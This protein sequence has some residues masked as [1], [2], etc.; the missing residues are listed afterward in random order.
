MTTS[1][2][3]NRNKQETEQLLHEALSQLGYL[4]QELA[5]AGVTHNAQ[6]EKIEQLEKTLGQ[7]ASS[8]LG[9]QAAAAETQGTQGESVE[10]ADRLQYYATAN[11]ALQAQLD[12]AITQCNMYYHGTIN[13]EQ[14]QS[15][16]ALRQQQEQFAHAETARHLGLLQHTH[17]GTAQHLDRVQRAHAAEAQ[18]CQQELAETETRYARILQAKDAQIDSLREK[19]HQKMPAE[20]RAHKAEA[21]RCQQELAES[22]ARYASMVQAKD[23]RIAGLTNNAHDKM[24]SLRKTLRQDAQS[25]GSRVEKALLLVTHT[26]LQ[27]DHTRQVALVGLRAEQ[28]QEKA[29]VLCIAGQYERIVTGLE[30]SLLGVCSA[31]GVLLDENSDTQTQLLMLHHDLDAKYEAQSTQQPQP[32]PALSRNDFNLIRIRYGTCPDPSTL[33][34]FQANLARIR[35]TAKHLP[36]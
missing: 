17:A 18:R 10:D 9:T 33:S 8:S 6:C 22:E 20:L 27:M 35:G 3:Q 26:A 30:Q 24:Q 16:A 29:D 14:R 15:M 31:A 25:L 13:L 2:P 1:H 19:V 12:T 36:T 4:E 23:A 21:Q 5:N 34:P 32:P 11:H 7:C 28:E